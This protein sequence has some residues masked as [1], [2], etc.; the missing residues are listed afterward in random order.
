VFLAAPGRRLAIESKL[1]EHLEQRPPFREAYDRLEGNVD[2]S[3]WAVYERLKRTPRS[4]EV[5]S[6]QA[7]SLAFLPAADRRRPA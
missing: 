5:P 4:Q 1:T 2:M 6:V 3:W 7:F